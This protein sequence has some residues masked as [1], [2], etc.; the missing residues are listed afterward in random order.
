MLDKCAQ[1]LLSRYFRA[2]RMKNRDHLE[3]ISLL[4]NFKKYKKDPLRQ[5]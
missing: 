4:W 3:A 5:I 1:N 2:I